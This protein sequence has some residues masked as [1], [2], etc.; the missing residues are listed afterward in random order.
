MAFAIGGGVAS[1]LTL[2]LSREN[3]FMA[4]L[5]FFVMAE[6]LLL[7]IQARESEAVQ[8]VIRTALS[9]THSQQRFSAYYLA[10]SIGSLR[11]ALR[12]LSLEG[13]RIMKDDVA[14]VRTDC[15]AQFDSE[16]LVSSYVTPDHWWRKDYAVENVDLRLTKARLGKAVRTLFIWQEWSELQRIAPEALRQRAAGVSVSHE[17]IA[18]I[19][20]DPVLKAKLKKI[21]TPD[22]GVIDGRWVFLHYLDRSRATASARL[23]DDPEIVDACNA[24]LAMTPG[25][26][27]FTST[28]SVSASAQVAGSPR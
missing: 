26:S 15:V 13:V 4:G 25:Q 28:A 23:T 16:L 11:N 5:I 18:R 2:H 1:N 9:S 27:D 12:N 22:F 14:R 17:S 21:G 10:L 19:K 20:T 6:L 24:F 8:S 7:L 3:S